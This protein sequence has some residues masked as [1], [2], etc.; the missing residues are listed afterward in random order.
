MSIREVDLLVDLASAQPGVFGA[1]MTGGGFGGA[2]VAAAAA[3]LGADAAENV[4]AEYRP[5]HGTLRNRARTGRAAVAIAVPILETP[6]ACCRGVHAS[7]RPHL[8]V[9]SPLEF[10]SSNDQARIGRPRV[11]FF[12]VI[13]ERLDVALLDRVAA[14]RPGWQVVL[15]G[16]S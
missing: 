3:G 7:R 2:I 5:A 9:S 4:R 11:G 1:R 12:G 6:W 14:A 15:V 8:P 13:D 16:P 10:F